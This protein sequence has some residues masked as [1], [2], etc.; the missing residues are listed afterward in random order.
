MSRKSGAAKVAAPDNS[1][2]S[3]QSEGT[4]GCGC[5]DKKNSSR[6]SK[7]TES[8]RSSKHSRKKN[9][10]K[11]VIVHT[12]KVAALA[13][14]KA[15]SSRGKAAITNTGMS[16]AQTARA[17]NPDLNSREL[18][19]AL[20]EQ[21]SKS[22]KSGQ[23]SSTRPTGKVRNKPSEQNGPATDAYWKVGASKTTH[24]K[25][26][27]GT[28]LDRDSDIT[29]NEHG[30]CRDITGTEYM[31]A[32]IFNKFCQ[33]DMKKSTLRSG[34]ST[35]HSGNQVTGNE[36][37]RSTAVTGD[38]PGTCKNITG[39]E[40]VGVEQSQAFC[41]TSKQEKPV[42]NSIT[43]TTRKGKS[44][45]GDNVNSTSK[46][47]G[48]EAGANRSLTGA[49]YIEESQR[50]APAKVGKST[51]V[52]GSL[53]TGTEVGR[54][55]KMTG[56]EAGS[57]RHVTG[58]DYISMEQFQS[59][60]GSSPEPQDRKVG[61]SMTLAG[62]R[63]T[64]T[65]NGRSQRVTGNEPGTCKSVTGTPYAGVDQFSQYCDSPAI[66]NIKNTSQA[67]YRQPLISMKLNNAQAS[68]QNDSA[69]MLPMDQ[70]FETQ[71]EHPEIVTE[72]N[73]Q[74]P[75]QQQERMQENTI[76][77]S[78][79]MPQTESVRQSAV[80]GTQYDLGTITGPFGMANGKVTGTDESRFGQN[81]SNTAM[82]NDKVELIE[83]RVKSRISGE[84]I[85]AG[86]KI[87]GDDWDR[88]ERV[89]GTEGF[90]SKVRNQTRRGNSINTT[91][92]MQRNREVV[93]PAP[94]PVSRVTGAS[95]NTG[96]GATITY[97]GGARG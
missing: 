19:K 86:P 97:S 91:D 20:R 89:T 18:S 33:T 58:D 84:G 22:G 6:L 2:N 4:C 67:K 96:N 12:S 47:T 30:Q 77:T 32:D 79:A 56:D 68:N 16:Q 63:V 13:R 93:N 29:G 72:I 49:Q 52:I 65:L 45:T 3:Q 5:K 8:A 31:G 40:Y 51:T 24:D 85:D 17:A 78:I 43:A 38:E 41:N 14:R 9:N 10:R 60:C 66:N 76:H 55:S 92:F 71:S 42:I 64:G 7:Y 73:N 94:T 50:E 87:S 1:E 61:V 75:E 28:M 39:T 23:K 70:A 95:G 48:G 53:I 62:E 81:M 27:T 90:S 59:F 46:V 82:P 69:P 11:K 74:V 21:R 83:G 57:C 88:G 34:H 80:T 36:V 25:T 54:A 44:V 26:V 15:L 35:T 37:G